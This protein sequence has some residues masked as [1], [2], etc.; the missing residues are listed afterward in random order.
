M[1]WRNKIISG[2]F[3]RLGFRL[4]SSFFHKFQKSIGCSFDGASIIFSPAGITRCLNLRSRSA[5]SSGP[6]IGSVS[7]SGVCSL[8]N[9][10][11]ALGGC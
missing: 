10:S 8:R 2:A 5:K 4:G 9:S 1:E 11:Q 7:I 3:A 6:V